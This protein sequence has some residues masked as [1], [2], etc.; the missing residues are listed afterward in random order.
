[1]MRRRS[2][3][4]HC[5]GGSP[6]RRRPGLAGVRGFSAPVPGPLGALGDCG[7]RRIRLGE[8]P[9]AQFRFQ[10]VAGLGILHQV[11]P[12]ILASLADPFAAVA[13]PGAALVDSCLSGCLSKPQ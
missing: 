5:F 9:L 4:K 7:E 12:G 2:P 11:L 10:P 1:M 3:V 8:D 6:S 13:E